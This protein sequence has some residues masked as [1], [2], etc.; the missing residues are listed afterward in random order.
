MDNKLN[1]KIYYFNIIV[2]SNEQLSRLQR[3]VALFMQTINTNYKNI[4]TNYGKLESLYKQK[5]II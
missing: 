3:K 5:S 1:F 4:I 2:C